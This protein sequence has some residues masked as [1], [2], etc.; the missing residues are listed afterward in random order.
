MQCVAFIMTLPSLKVILRQFY[1][2]VYSQVIGSHTVSLSIASVCLR[3]DQMSVISRH[4]TFITKFDLFSF[5][6]ANMDG[7]GLNRAPPLGFESQ[8]KSFTR[9]VPPPDVAA[10]RPKHTDNATHLRDELYYHLPSNIRYSY[11]PV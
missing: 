2:F 3:H 8:N 11:T 5:L 7:F 6:A 1:P 9:T 4:F 10:Y